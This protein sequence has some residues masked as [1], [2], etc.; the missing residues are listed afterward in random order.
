MT[1]ATMITEHFT[2]GH[3]ANSEGY[4]ENRFSRCCDVG[5]GSRVTRGCYRPA[6]L[7]VSSI[8]SGPTVSLSPLRCPWRGSPRRRNSRSN[9]LLATGER[10]HYY[11][12]IA[13]VKKERSRSRNP[14]K[15]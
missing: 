7:G 6:P 8:K 5:W 14:P 15:A 1:W 10:Q 11:Y 3:R 9:R 4:G 12:G 2:N 13:G